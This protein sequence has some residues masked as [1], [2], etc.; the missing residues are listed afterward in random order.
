M[1]ER[2]IMKKILNRLAL[3]AGTL[4]VI[5]AGA[6]AFSA[7]EAHVINV[8]AK[9]ENAMNVPIKFLDYGT[10][11][12]Q[13]YLVKDVPVTLSASFL[14][15]GRV[16]D[17]EYF[18]RQK[19]KCAIT[20]NGGT[21]YDDTVA[22]DG[23][24]AYTRTGHVVVEGETTRIDCGEAPRPL[25]VDDPQTDANEAETW[26]V[27]PSLC[28]Y[29]SKHKE[30]DAG[31]SEMESQ[32]NAF[33]QPYTVNQGQIVW[34]DAKGYLTKLGNDTTD[35]WLID[36]AVPCFGGYCA[37]DWA[38][39]VADKNPNA[40]DPQQWTQPIANEHK[41]FGC[42]LWIE[43]A[44]VSQTPTPE[45]TPTPTPTGTL[46]I[47]KVLTNLGEGQINATSSDF[48]F[49]VDDGSTVSFEADG[50][51]SIVVTAGA[52][53]VSEAVA[54]GYTITYSGDCDVNGG[55]TVPENG[56]ATCTITNTGNAIPE[57]SPTP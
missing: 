17:V 5:I 27:L 11:F 21:E 19:P 23:Q 56:S 50:S 39:Y 53:T 22:Q 43:V 3:S 1:D 16:D 9:I 33:H 12:P 52:H 25:A 30:A 24:H 38:A 10:V 8:T 42:D 49:K 45:P 26:G 2:E 14:A 29:L 34:N 13:E 55:I 4:G 44:G 35:T 41:I 51:N 57:P 7:F 48:S 46:T 37:Q 54:D 40:G 31:Q 36:L 28:P 20:T 47:T 15:E 6:A 18:I 32:I